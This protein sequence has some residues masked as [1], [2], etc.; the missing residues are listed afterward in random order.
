MKK[1][2]VIHSQSKQIMGVY[3]TLRRAWNKVDKLD[4]AIGGYR[5]TVVTVEV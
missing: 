1:Y 3:S 4:N 2:Q 5:Y